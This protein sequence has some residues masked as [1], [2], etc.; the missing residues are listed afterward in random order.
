MTEPE[1]L[2]VDEIFSA[3]D[4]HFIK[5]GTERMLH[6]FKS[7]QVVLFVS[8]NLDQIRQLCN[9]VVVLHHGQVINQGNPDE[10]L[11]FYESKIVNPI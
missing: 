5:K 3:G 10:M 2:L 1:I 7:S 6:L 9:Q 8:H 4:A 11:E